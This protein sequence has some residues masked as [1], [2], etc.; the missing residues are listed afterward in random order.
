M[1]QGP[2]AA[3][4]A[5]SQ[6]YA[7]RRRSTRIN[8]ETPV[9]L[10]GRDARGEIY[11][12]ETITEIV[13]IHGARVRTGRKILVGMLVSIECLK[14]GRG[15]KGVCVN[16]YEPTAEEPHPAIA[17]QLLQPGNIWGVENPPSDWATVAATLG[18]GISPMESSWSGVAAAQS[19]AAPRVK[20]FPKQPAHSPSA[21]QASDRAQ[22]ATE[23]SLARLRDEAEMITR[24]A[25][26]AHDQR[27]SERTAQAE[28]RLAECTEQSA[29]ELAASVHVLKANIVAELVQVSMEEVKA[30]LE[31]IARA[32]EEQLTQHAARLAAQSE[33]RLAAKSAEE[34][35]ASEKALEEWLGGLMRKTEARVTELTER[36]VSELATAAQALKVSLPAD[37]VEGSKKALRPS[38][39]EISKT[40]KEQLS[41]HAARLVNES[42][43]HLAAKSAEEVQAGEKALEQWLGG[44]MRKAEAD[45]AARVSEALQGLEVVISNFRASFADDLAAQNEKSIQEAEQALRSRLA[46]MLSSIMAP[47]QAAPVTSDPAIKK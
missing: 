40:Y 46:A 4:K 21:Q 42:G 27:L 31:G 17:M 34:V 1:G 6:S 18:G 20:S 41:Q 24:S 29:T 28:A 8:H 12:D 10:S 33:E 11:R 3:R 22:K 38:L 2:F 43:A 26:A 32:Q 44:L 39:E 36:A 13:N 30:R 37:L 23:E 35:Q 5:D 19:E 16:V 9:I 15:S 47:G 14:T 7:N 25:L 45:Q